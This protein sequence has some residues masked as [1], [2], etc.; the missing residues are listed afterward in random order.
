MDYI[1]EDISM[2]TS[3]LHR[4]EDECRKYE[5][6][7]SGIVVVVV[8]V[9]ELVVVVVVVL[10]YVCTGQSFMCYLILTQCY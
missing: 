9:L 1:Q 2:M 8:V 6:S 3:E 7:G 5:V 4:W 10:V